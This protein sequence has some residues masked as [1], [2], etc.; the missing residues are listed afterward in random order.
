MS[1]TLSGP[2]VAAMLAQETGEVVC[3]AMLIEHDDLDEPIRVTDNG[4]DVVFGGHT[5][6]HF[7]YE[8]SLPVDVEDRPPE[9]MLSFDN[10]GYWDDDAGT[11]YSP[12]ETIRAL[13]GPL[14]ITIYVINATT[15]AASVVE[16]TIPSMKLRSV[17]YD[18]FSVSGTLTYLPLLDE[19]FPGH[20]FTPG[21]FPMIF[22]APSYEWAGRESLSGDPKAAGG[23]AFRQGRSPKTQITG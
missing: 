4:E 3:T 23:L 21:R 12:T 5:Y 16:V 13:S 14:D 17:E 15:P 1:R 9:A 11:E 6:Q 2:T 7:P 8:V 18:Q 20:T 22:G 10:I 19:Q